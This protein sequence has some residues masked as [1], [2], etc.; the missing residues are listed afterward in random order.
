M[1]RAHWF[2]HFG[3]QFQQVPCSAA[4]PGAFGVLG[5]RQQPIADQ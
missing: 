5:Q 3:H 1:D 4:Q 2:Q